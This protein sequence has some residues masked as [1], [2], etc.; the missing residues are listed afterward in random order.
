MAAERAE[1]TERAAART[2]GERVQA[3][4]GKGRSTALAAAAEKRLTIV[5]VKMSRAAIAGTMAEYPGLSRLYEANVP[6]KMSEQEFWSRFLRQK[7]RL[8]QLGPTARA[9]RS[10]AAACGGG[11][12]ARGAI[13][14]A[15]GGDAAACIDAAT[16]GERESISEA[17][18]TAADSA[19]GG[20]AGS[21]DADA[22]AAAAA[23]SAPGGAGGAGG[24]G[25]VGQKRVGG[26]A[27][28]EPAAKKH[29]GGS[30]G[31]KKG[32]NQRRREANARDR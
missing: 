31:K 27:G 9:A 29:R 6:G 22:G 23:E 18:V 12:A 2:A 21:S 14:E 4:T 7:T 32:A 26:A 3:A 13:G 25:A 5:K 15:A 11:G 10:T 8:Q 1:A 20:A 30:K 16:D 19:P 24:E 17:D 28:D